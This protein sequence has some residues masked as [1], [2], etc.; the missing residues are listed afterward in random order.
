[1]TSFVPA[2]LMGRCVTQI[3]Q[4]TAVRTE[5]LLIE[6]WGSPHSEHTPRDALLTLLQLCLHAVMGKQRLASAES[7][8]FASQN[9]FSKNLICL[10]VL[11]DLALDMS[12]SPHE[13]F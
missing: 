9:K 7:N 12:L 3:R 6:H 8:A 1:M 2:L 13:L 10:S 4:Q 11:L 5:E